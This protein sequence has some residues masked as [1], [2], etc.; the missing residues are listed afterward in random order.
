MCIH[1]DIYIYTT[2]SVAVHGVHTAR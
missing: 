1:I 2:I